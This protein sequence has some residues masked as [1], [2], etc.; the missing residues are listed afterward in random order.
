LQSPAA[1]APQ[2]LVVG[3]SSK[4]G[5]AEAESSA[6]EAESMAPPTDKEPEP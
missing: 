5:V 4:A 3:S 6:L 1:P 2:L